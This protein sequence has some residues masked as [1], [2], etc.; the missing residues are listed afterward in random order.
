MPLATPRSRATV[1]L[2]ALALLAALLAFALAGPRTAVQAQGQPPPGPVSYSGN[3]TVGGAP[4]PDGIHIVARIESPLPDNDYESQPRATLNGEYKNLIVGPTSVLFNFRIISFHIIAVG[5]SITSHL[6]PEGLTAVETPN[7]IPG[8]NIIDGYDLTFP[9]IPPAPT[10]TPAP[11]TPTPEAVDTPV[12]EDTPTPEP[13]STPE[14][15]ATPEPTSTPTPTVT[16][17]PT[18]TPVPTPAPTATPQPTPTAVVI[19]VTATPSIEVTPIVELEP[20]DDEPGTCGQ[21]S[22]P[23][24]YVLLAGLGLVG[25]VWMRRR[26]PLG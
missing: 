14:P 22:R 3:V 7:F 8:P 12:P 19:V 2:L 18:S 9:A 13:T 11:A 21:G 4:A 5:D 25:L 23:D 20:D 15:T 6:G 24:A 1:A 17:T 10:P 16:P 26:R